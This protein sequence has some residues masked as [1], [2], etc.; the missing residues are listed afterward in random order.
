MRHILTLLKYEIRVL[1]TAP[2]T[3]VAAVIFLLLMG[4]IYLIILQDFSQTAQEG[5][6]SEMFFQLFWLPVFFVV[7]LLTMKSIAEERRLGTL[8]TLMT[9]PVTALEVVVS[10]FLASYLL[11]CLLWGLTLLFPILANFTF[12]TTVVGERLL[13]RATLMGGYLFVAISG[14]L[15]IAVG[16]F[17][18]SLTRTQLV[19]G[20]LC[21]SILFILILGV[22]ALE[23]QDMEW[24][25]WLEAPLSYLQIFNHLAD[26]SRGVIDTR[27]LFYY[28]SNTLLVLGLTVIMVESKT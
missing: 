23:A 20:M 6:P 19:A 12:E 3:Y 16:I 1:I 18:S 21:F 14:M 15:F 26:F 13:D 2:A 10:K 25:H 5:L 8:G 7:P 24:M 4:F 17:S 9:T 22:S 11:Y 28:S 27:P